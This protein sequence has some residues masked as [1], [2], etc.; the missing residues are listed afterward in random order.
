[1]AAVTLVPSRLFAGDFVDVEI[2]ADADDGK[3][4]MWNKTLQRAVWM[5]L[6]E[7]ESYNS[8]SGEPSLDFSDENNSMYLGWW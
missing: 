3:V 5:T 2:P 7:V 1:M 6:A 8:A 4:M